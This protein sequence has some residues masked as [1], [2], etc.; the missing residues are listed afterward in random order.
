MLNDFADIE[1]LSTADSVGE[2][3]RLLDEGWE[4]L[5][6]HPAPP[7]QGGAFGSPTTI[8]V[9]A[10]YAEWD[11]DLDESDLVLEELEPLPS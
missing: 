7:S 1:E 10:R 5:G 8:F 4:L 2:A 3:N 11:E 6:F 9:M